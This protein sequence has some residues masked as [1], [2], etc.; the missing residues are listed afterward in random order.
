MIVW[1]REA[2]RKDSMEAEKLWEE[3]DEEEGWW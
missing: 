3:E 2:A 1:Y